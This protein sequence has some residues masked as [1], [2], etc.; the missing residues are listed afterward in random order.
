MA[1]Q[2]STADIL[3]KLVED[4]SSIEQEEAFSTHDKTSVKNPIEYPLRILASIKTIENYLYAELQRLR[5][6]SA[7][8][9]IS[10]VI[11]P[12]AIV[13]L[14]SF[15]MTL[16]AWRLTIS[17]LAAFTSVIAA[18]RMFLNI[19]SRISRYSFILNK[20]IFFRHRLE[21][22]LAEW[23][24]SVTVADKEL[25]ELAD[26]A[27]EIISELTIDIPSLKVVSLKTKAKTAGSA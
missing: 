22:A 4:V 19:D 11:L 27:R 2:D 14:T 10:S 5:K 21:L 3:S 12:A 9:S 7:L 8:L 26:Q 18:L 13:S 6:V 1:A 17:L 25:F 20:I 15:D 16:T 24:V 23:Q